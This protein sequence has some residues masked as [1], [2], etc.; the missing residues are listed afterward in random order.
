[1]NNSI[2]NTDSFE[3][4]GSM[5]DFLEHMPDYQESAE[6]LVLRGHLLIEKIL[7]YYI[8][9]ML[10]NPGEF[11]H[12][13]FNFDKALIL[14]RALTPSEVNT[15]VFEAAK[16]LNIARNEIAH[17]LDLQKSENKIKQFI[18]FVEKQP[19]DFVVPPKERNETR[20]YLAISDLHHELLNVF[21][22]SRKVQN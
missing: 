6:L 16:K 9:H 12:E 10:T 22:Y 17:G 8:D 13:N 20:L 5:R 11:K 19:I 4:F 7:R 1:M 18:N 3:M 21:H 15:W 14:C 2:Q